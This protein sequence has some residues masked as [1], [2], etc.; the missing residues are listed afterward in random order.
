M[1]LE[2]VSNKTLRTTS[3]GEK[4][5]QHQSNHWKRWMENWVETRES[6]TWLSDIPD[7]PLEVVERK[8]EQLL[9]PI[10]DKFLGGLANTVKVVTLNNGG[11]GYQNTEFGGETGLDAKTT[12]Y[13][14]AWD[15]MKDTV[16]DYDKF[17]ANYQK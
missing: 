3:G 9:N 10:I 11:L 2:I 12:V 1:P 14:N 8:V 7:V 15:M 6:P 16:P 13:N 4:V 17:V 5:K